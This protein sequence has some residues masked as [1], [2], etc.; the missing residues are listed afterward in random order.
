MQQQAQG[1][2]ILACS[3]HDKDKQ[4]LDQHSTRVLI[5]EEAG[6]YSAFGN[7]VPEELSAA[8][9]KIKLLFTV[10]PTT[11]IIIC[12]LFT[13]ASI[14]VQEK[15]DYYWIRNEIILKS[16]ESNF[17]FISS[18]FHKIIGEFN[19][20]SVIQIKYQGYTAGSWVDI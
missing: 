11:V 14:L 7:E 2:S 5:S 17:F 3:K 20:E 13:A 8:K 19:A 12:N 4:T 16:T 18:D 9:K 15:I 1:L 6:K 10:S